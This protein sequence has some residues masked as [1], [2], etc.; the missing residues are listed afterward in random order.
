MGLLTSQHRSL[1]QLISWN[2]MLD[3]THLSPAALCFQLF[4]WLLPFSLH[5]ANLIPVQMM[6]GTPK[7]SFLLKL[8]ISSAQGL[9]PVVRFRASLRISYGEG[10]SGS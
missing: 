1:L 9:P 7:P 8:L 4:H 3:L 6:L 2:A 5:R 10:T